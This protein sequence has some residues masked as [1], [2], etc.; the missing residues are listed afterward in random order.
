MP[1]LPPNFTAPAWDF[2]SAAPSWS[3]M[4][5]ACGLSTTLHA[6]LA[7]TLPYPQKS[8][9]TNDACTRPVQTRAMSVKSLLITTAAESHDVPLARVLGAGA[10]NSF[11]Q[12]FP[13]RE[14]LDRCG[15]LS[16]EDPMD[17][18]Y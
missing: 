3:R 6:A 18:T 9:R 5:D 10:G 4:A 17:P 12:F 7:F 16:K 11:R 14:R 15:R 1:S 2:G 13:C 8:R